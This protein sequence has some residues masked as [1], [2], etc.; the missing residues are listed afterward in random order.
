MLANPAYLQPKQVRHG[1][2]SLILVSIILLLALVAGLVCGWL[3]LQT[4]A[5][6][7]AS[8]MY[9]NVYVVGM[10]LGRMTHEEA[11][12]L[13]SSAAPRV[14]DGL[15]VLDDGQNRWSVPWSEAGLFLDVPATIQAAFAIGHRD[16]LSWREQVQQWLGRHDV[17][18]AFGVN[19]DAARQMLQN[20]APSVFVAPTDATL[21]LPQ[22]A[23][24]PV[25]VLPGQPG[26]ELDVDATLSQLLALASGQSPTTTVR[27][28]FRTVSPRIADLTPL[29][30][31]VEELLRR[32]I[33]LSTYDALTDESFSWQLGRSD[34]VAWLA[35]TTEPAGPTITV[36][37]TAIQ[38]TLSKLASELGAGRGFRLT[39]ATQQVADGFHAGGGSVALYLTHPERT[40]VVEPGDSLGK[41][42]AVFGMTSWHVL[43]ANPGL[44]PDWLVVGQQLTIPSP[45]ILTPYLPVA[46]KRIVISVAEQRMRV[47]ENGALLHEWPVSTGVAKSPTHTGVFQILSQEENA[48][49]SLWDLWMP[50]FQAIYAAGPDFYN[51]IHGLPTLSSGRR[52]WEGLLGSPASYGCIILGLEEAETLYQWAERGVVVVV[53]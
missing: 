2:S 29:R 5:S 43:Q 6:Y 46:D 20:L 9:P 17:A 11:S 12:A 36:D 41:V 53:E 14:E 21:R 18:P 52:L 45:D 31:Q 37:E 32:R 1:H 4:V 38:A 16:G 49:A 19:A 39:E 40:Y 24:D 27:L 25:L 22:K 50:H 13:L 7:Y 42:A 34:I 26:R 35:V 8:R 47:Y 33:Q 48:Y 3:M 15:L 28:V 30:A 44:N 51:G 10:K 23:E